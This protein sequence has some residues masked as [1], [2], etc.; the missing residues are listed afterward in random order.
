MGRLRR[1]PGGWPVR[2][3]LTCPSSCRDKPV[4]VTNLP[5][6]GDPPCKLS[7][8]HR[9]GPGR[10]L[11]G[12]IATRGLLHKARL[13]RRA[14]GFK[15]TTDIHLGM[16]FTAVMPGSRSIGRRGLPSVQRHPGIV[17]VN[18]KPV[19]GGRA[20]DSAHFTSVL[21]QGCHR[22]RFRPG[23]DASLTQGFNN[24]LATSAR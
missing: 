4:V 5:R 23:L 18:Y 20:H 13:G 14:D 9:G 8:I 17:T 24:C 21:L 1:S 22:F 15:P 3:Q 12:W 10:G 7:G 16:G 2:A 19:Q 6:A 11:R